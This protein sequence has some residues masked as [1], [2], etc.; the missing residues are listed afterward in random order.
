MDRKSFVAFE[1]VRCSLDISLLIF[2]K[3]GPTLWFG[4]DYKSVTGPVRLI[5]LVPL[6]VVI[7]FGMAVDD[8]VR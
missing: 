1:S 4:I 8:D 3:L 2:S 7:T 5:V 6:L